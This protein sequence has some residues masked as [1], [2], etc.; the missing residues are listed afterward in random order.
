MSESKSALRQRLRAIR[1]A[2]DENEQ[3]RAA[4]H[5]VRHSKQLHALR[6]ARMV[7]C[8]LPQ[9]GE[10]GTLPL[11]ELCWRLGKTVHLPVISHIPWERLWFAPYT[12]DSELIINRYG[13]PEPDVHPCRQRRAQ[14]LDI[15][16]MPMVGFDQNG[17]RMGMG[18]AFYDKSLAFLQHRRYWRQP[19]LIGLA[20]ECQRV[21]ALEP[22]PWDIP[23]DA[24]ITEEKTYTFRPAPPGH[25]NRL[26]AL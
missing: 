26:R 25:N 13:I 18:K 21:D 14:S 3:Q 16:F 12:P 17:N 6:C 9:G 15:I 2:V 19:K 1:A 8:Y 7:A 24:I 4:L 5:I 10:V 22:E 11:I 23:L 20:Y